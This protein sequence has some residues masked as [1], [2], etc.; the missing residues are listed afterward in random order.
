MRNFLL[1]ALLVLTSSLSVAAQAPPDLAHA[2]VDA[3]LRGDHADAD[4]FSSQFLAQVSIT[5]VNA[6]LAQ[7]KQSLGA[8]RSIEGTRGDYIAHFEKG[9]DEV[10][11]HLDSDNKIDGLFFKPPS[12]QALSLSDG[13]A[14][15]AKSAGT[16]SYVIVDGRTDVAALDP[17][18]PLAVGSS[19]K[20]AVLAALSDEIAAG[21]LH[22]T[23]VVPLDA[24][25]KSLP[26]GE[27]QNWPDKTPLTLA[28]YADE[29]ISISDNTATDALIS[30]IGPAPL[31][32][33]AMGNTPFPT[34]R[35][36]LVLKAASNAAQESAY[37]SA[38]TPAERSLALHA[39]DTLPLPSIQDFVSHPL[40]QVEW[41]YSVRDLCGLMKRVA[42]LPAM[43]INAGV[44]DPAA[45]AHVAF[46]GGSDTGLINLT[47]QVTTKRGTTLC[48]SATLNDA[49][50]SVDE[51]GFANAYASVLR[52]LTDR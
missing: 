1:A 11:V 9:T 46:K 18:S 8:Y 47:T 27:L 51:R 22:W 43:T 49:A 45:F 50:G 6:I 31:A 15:L 48:F 41:H 33:Y 16:L 10:L 4:W 34:T 14:T 2:R 42:D 40:L 32:P 39:A 30:I 19:F 38:Q 3:M 44:A 25:W 52:A 17:S 23:D 7:F 5:Q 12:V 26:S 20:L 36:M 13:L 37:V 21:H 24:A 28:T 35:E 29:M